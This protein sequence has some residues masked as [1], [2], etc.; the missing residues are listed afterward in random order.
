MLR[1]AWLIPLLPALS[2]VAILLFGKRLPR[3]G[4]EL[5]VGAVGASFVLASVAAVQWIDR[6]E[7]A[8][9]GHQ[10]LRAFGRGL[11]AS[12]GGEIAVAPVI[13]GLTW[14]QNGNVEFGAD[15][16]IDDIRAHYHQV[17]FATGA[18]TD[19]KLNIPGED[20]PGSHPATEFVAWYNGHPDYRHLQFDLSRERAV[21]IGVGNGAVDVARILSLAPVELDRTDMAPYAI[22]ALSQ[23]RVREVHLVGRPGP[24]PAPGAKPARN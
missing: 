14:W 5:G 16:S 3:K 12:E 4:A 13:R 8:E 21:I 22:E 17:L 6:V 9:G 10:G 1:N 11:L 15:I 20:L 23:S 24:G 7:G 19:R 2:F 18:Q